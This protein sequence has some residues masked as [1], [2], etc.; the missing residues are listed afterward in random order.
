[1][2]GIQLGNGQEVKELRVWD[3]VKWIAKRGRIFDGV[4][5]IDFIR[6]P[7]SFKDDMVTTTGLA[8]R[9]TKTIVREPISVGQTTLLV[10]N[11]IGFKA[12]EE[13]TIADGVKSE[14]VKVADINGNNSIISP[15][16]NSYKNNSLVARTNAVVENN[17]LVHSTHKT[18]SVQ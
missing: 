9:L 5:W 13:I 1:M 8:R 12:G 14:N 15:T 4:K 18:Y 17:Q 16:K 11:A 3:G 7:L 2:A 6:P 10:Q